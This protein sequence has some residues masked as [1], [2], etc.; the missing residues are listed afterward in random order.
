MKQDVER[1]TE[2]LRTLFPETPLQ[3]NEHLSARY[4]AQVYLKRE[5]LSPVRSYKIRGA[6]NLIAQL[7]PEERARGVI[8]YSSGNHG[9]AVALSAQILGAPAVIVMPTTAPA[10]KV[11]GAR[12]YGAEVQFAGTTSTDRQQ[13]AEAEA[14]RRGLTIVPPFDH[15]SIIAG[16]GTAGL[17]IL[18]Q[19]PGVSTIFVPIGGG[20]QV[21]GIA[22]AIKLSRPS[23]R[24]VGVEPAGAPTMK[25]AVAVWRRVT[26]ANLTP[27]PTWVVGF[28]RFEDRPSC[29]FPADQR[30]DGCSIQV[31]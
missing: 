31:Y 22:A 21:S 25:T 16:Q 14:A 24:I 4:G 8:T 26:A 23:V 30:A 5:D 27:Q 2:A 11:E 19:C 3:L 10:V 28:H 15:P 12:S 7:T 9:Q 18:E 29:P 13:H 20:G 17:E 6:F 1:A